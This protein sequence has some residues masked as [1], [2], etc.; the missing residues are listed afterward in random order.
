MGELACPLEVSIIVTN[1]SKSNVDFFLLQVPK[2]AELTPSVLQVNLD[3][4]LLRH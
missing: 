1:V 3:V 4:Y 2:M